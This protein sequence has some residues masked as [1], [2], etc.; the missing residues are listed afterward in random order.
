[1]SFFNNLLRCKN[2]DLLMNTGG[3]L[4]NKF[5]T[6]S[7]GENYHSTVMDFRNILNTEQFEEFM[8]KDKLNDLDYSQLPNSNILITCEHATNNFHMYQNKLSKSDLEYVDTHWGYDPGAKDAGINLAESLNSMFIAT[9]FSRLILDPN[10]SVLSNTLIRK[11]VEIDVELD[12]NK[13]P[14]R[15]ERINKFYIPYHN[16]LYEVLSFI[17]PKYFIQM[18]SFTGKYEKDKFRDFDIGLLYDTENELTKRL[19]KAFEENKISYKL[20]EPY[21]MDS[22]LNAFWNISNYN[23]PQT[24]DGVLIE[25]RNDKA[26]DNEYAAN[27]NEVM[28]ECLIDLV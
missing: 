15:E 14:D 7:S 23:Y 20:N 10:R 24:I 11:N 28:T 16:I 6:L 18:H 8:E 25:I 26:T 3:S 2:S 27:L 21:K 5:R 17:N 13:N 22:N 9:N 4:T 1:M 12:I 19:I